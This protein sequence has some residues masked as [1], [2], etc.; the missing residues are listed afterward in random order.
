M[1]QTFL[2]LTLVLGMIA[3]TETYADTV[4]EKIDINSAEL[5]ILDRELFG[6][7]PKKAAA[8]VKYRKEN[9]PFQSIEDIQKVFG[10][11]EKTFEKN[12][13]KIIVVQPETS[14]TE[15]STETEA[16]T[17]ETVSADVQEPTTPASS[18]DHPTDNP[19]EEVPATDSVTP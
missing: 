14:L 19:T 9:G 11:G 3:F 6:I 10:I 16:S 8:I 18:T 13:D 4:V 12:K 2:L 17:T 1:R 7:G 5:D 15:A